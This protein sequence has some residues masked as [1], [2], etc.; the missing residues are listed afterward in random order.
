M[1][2]AESVKRYRT[3]AFGIE[4]MAVLITFDRPNQRIAAEPWWEIVPDIYRKEVMDIIQ[5]VFDHY[6]RR[7]FP[8]ELI[9][10]FI[11]ELNSEIRK[12]LPI[13]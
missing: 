10:R 6:V 12:R 2:N 11:D 3:L 8:D 13:R 7:P 1:T 4:A 9:E 5:D